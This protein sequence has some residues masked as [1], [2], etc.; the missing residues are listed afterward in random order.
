[1]KKSPSL[2]ITEEQHVILSNEWMRRYIEE[3]ERYER[4]WE[5]V[6]R[7]LKEEKK[8]KEPSYGENCNAYLKELRDE[9]FPKKSAKPRKQ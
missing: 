2:D 8:G 3:P 1:M 5:T 4:E 9:L 7:F 6:T